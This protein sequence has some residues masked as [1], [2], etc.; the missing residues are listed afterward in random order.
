MKTQWRILWFLFL[1]T[2]LAALST[3]AW[4]HAPPAAPEVTAAPLPTKLVEI[5]VVEI[6]EVI[7]PEVH[8]FSISV[9]TGHIW[10]GAGSYGYNFDSSEWQVQASGRWD[11]G[12]RIGIG[13]GVVRDTATVQKWFVKHKFTTQEPPEAYK[14]TGVDLYAVL[15]FNPD[16]K[17]RVY[18]LLGGTWYKSG[19][20]SK[21]GVVGGVGL[22]YALTR[23]VF[24]G[25]TVKVRHV[26][27]FIVPV[28]NVAETGL[29]L[30][31][32]F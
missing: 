18:A 19:E 26:Q 31:F 25:V 30:G 11:I 24:V 13:L 10:T 21:A 3:G 16:D 23:Q 9:G 6:R 12:R 1:A 15:F 17:A 2:A 7:A 4:A 14:Y 22:E 28:A 27:D 29:N 5:P 32:R 20:L 8:P